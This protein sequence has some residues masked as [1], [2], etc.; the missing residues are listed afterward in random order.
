MTVGEARTSDCCTKKE[1]TGTQEKILG[2]HSVAKKSNK[3]LSTEKIGKA[4]SH[5][6]VV[7]PYKKSNKKKSY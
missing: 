3:K 5:I 6:H 1:R 2:E 4:R 7:K